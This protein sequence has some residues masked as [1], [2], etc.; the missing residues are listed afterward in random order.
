MFYTNFQTAEDTAAGTT[1]ENPTVSNG[2]SGPTTGASSEFVTSDSSIDIGNFLSST[3][4]VDNSKAV[5]VPGIEP[6]RPEV[7]NSTSQPATPTADSL[8]QA[9]SSLKIVTPPCGRGSVGK[10]QIVSPL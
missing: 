6:G 3:S 4:T 8:Y 9:A 7:T 1:T 5:E 10:S 2:A